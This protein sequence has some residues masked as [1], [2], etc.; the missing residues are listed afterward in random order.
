MQ[1]VNILISEK[2]VF[3][4]Y[5]VFLIEVLKLKRYVRRALLILSTP[6]TQAYQSTSILFSVKKT[7]IIFLFS[8]EAVVGRISQMAPKDVLF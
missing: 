4:N 1:T 8:E 5:T 7:T 3:L 2:K 6:E